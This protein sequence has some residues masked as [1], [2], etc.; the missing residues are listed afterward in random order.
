MTKERTVHMPLAVDEALARVVANI[1]PLAAG[2]VPLAQAEGRVLAEDVRGPIAL[3]PFANS[4]MDG[5]AVIASDTASASAMHPVRLSIAERIAA[6]QVAGS[7]LAPGH[8]ARIMTGA[9]IPPGADAVVKFEDTVVPD[10]AHIDLLAAVA[11]GAHVR[12]PGEDLPEGALALRAGTVL[13][14]AA[15]GLLAALGRA[16]VPCVRPP[17]VA[18]LVTGDE[19]VPPGQPLPAAKIYDANSVLIAGLVRRFGGEV[20]WQ[21]TA[22][23]EEEALRAALDA[24]LAAQ[25]DLIVTTGG[26]SMGDFD[27]V[28]DVL[29][30]EGCIEFWQVSMRPGRPIAFGRLHDVPLLGL[31][32]NSVA[33][34]VGFLLFGRAILAA[35]QGQPAAPALLDAV[36]AEPIRNGS[37]RRNFLRGIASVRDAQIEVRQAGGQGPNHLSPLAG[38]NCLIVAGEDTAMNERGSTVK[39]LLLEPGL[40]PPL[41]TGDA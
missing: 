37:G 33:A 38:S 6:G 27:L 15:L 23:D 12:L 11:P 30:H 41:E 2:R 40:W 29:A 18:V 9:A 24:A 19:I 20:A 22:P 36:C 21:S 13:H 10:D 16:E 26:V 31:P 1:H 28:K 7:R 14:P 32:G 39:I 5:Y 3:P 35:L 17:R 25:P 4:A 34:Y 8:A